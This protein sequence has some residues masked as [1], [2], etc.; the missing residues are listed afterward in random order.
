MQKTLNSSRLPP[1]QLKNQNH[2]R[3]ASSRESMGDWMGSL[4]EVDSCFGGSE[5]HLETVSGLLLQNLK[6]FHALETRVMHQE[7]QTHHQV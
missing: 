1:L 5:V 3:Q 2:T 6:T 7:I 4:H